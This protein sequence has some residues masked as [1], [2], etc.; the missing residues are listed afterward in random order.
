[1]PLWKMTTSIASAPLGGLGSNTWHARTLSA[2][3]PG[4]VDAASQLEDL[5]D[6]VKGLYQNLN[7]QLLGGTTISFEG[8]WVSVDE[9]EAVSVATPAWSV[10]ITGS[11]SSLP[12]A[13]SIV[14]GWRTSSPTK[15]GRGRTF[16]GPLKSTVLEGNGTPAEAELAT[17][18]LAAQTLV[19]ASTAYSGNG[20]LGV[21]SR[22][23][24]TA[25]EN[26][27]FRDFTAVVVH[28]KFASL[29]SRRD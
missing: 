7:G 11:A 3:G 26:G 20:A 19:D 10:G 16:L 2:I 22:A 27:V 6:L 29:R 9:D 25:L 13:D 23:G 14:L 17:I 21:Y 4:P 1:M 8:Q 12:P 24:K 15:G 18:R 28:N 5:G